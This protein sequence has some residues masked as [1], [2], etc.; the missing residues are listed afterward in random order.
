MTYDKNEKK[1]ELKSSEQ[2]ATAT[3]WCFP[4]L[5][6]VLC[7]S[8]ARVFF[9]WKCLGM[10]SLILISATI[11]TSESLGLVVKSSGNNFGENIFIKAS[12]IWGKVVPG[13]RATLQ[14]K[15]TLAGV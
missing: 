9:F 5:S 12:F 8:I 13:R 14:A 6:L 15:T 11:A 1:K 4:Q 7:S 3:F 2:R 10:C